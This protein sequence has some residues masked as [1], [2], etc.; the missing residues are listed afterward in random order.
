MARWGRALRHLADPTRYPGVARALDN[1]V[2]DQPD[3]PDAEFRFGLGRLLDGLELR[4]NRPS[5]GQGG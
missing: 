2:L 1:G 4:V 5:A 3:E